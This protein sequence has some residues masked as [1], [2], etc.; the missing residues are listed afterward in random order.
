MCVVVGSS[1][2]LKR[3][4]EIKTGDKDFFFFTIR[5]VKYWHRLPR[6]L[7]DALSLETFRVR[8]AGTLS[9]VM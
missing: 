4:R 9:N 8:L 5:V 7:V 2:E 3:E 6:Q 1:E